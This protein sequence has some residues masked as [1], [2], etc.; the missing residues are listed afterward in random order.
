MI[1]RR[2]S[3]TGIL[4]STVVL[5]SACGAGYDW[6]HASTLNTVA[7][8]QRFLSKYPTDPHA[9]DAQSRIATLQDKRAWT[10]AQIYFN[11]PRLPAIFDS[12]TERRICASGS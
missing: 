3:L 4:C 5:L 8:Y 11:C 9:V 6:S 10:M 12:R 2:L 1:L 7:A